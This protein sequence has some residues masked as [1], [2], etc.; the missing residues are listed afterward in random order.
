MEAVLFIGVILL[1]LGAV[2][3]G[4]WLRRAI[5]DYQNDENHK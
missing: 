2:W 3:V 1:V 4:D 5:D